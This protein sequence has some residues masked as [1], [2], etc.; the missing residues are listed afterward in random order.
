M[1]HDLASCLI[2]DVAEA[3]ARAIC[4][5]Y[6]PYVTDTTITFEVDI[7]SVDEMRERIRVGT[8]VLPWLVA[9]ADGLIVAYAYATRW[10]SRA[11]Y[12]RTAETT[13]YVRAGAH[14]QGVGYPL[15]IALLDALR[16][17]SVHVAIGGIA[18]PNPASVALHEKCGFAKVAHFPQVGRKFD[19]WVD[20][21][22][23]QR[24]L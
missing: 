24:L 7:V 9:E 22:F 11:A 4:D 19:G 15:Y 12:D 21:G 14:R 18:L 3:D 23:W 5:I 16:R 6:N 8:Q 1:S 20:V 10:R 2:R 13:V 17:H